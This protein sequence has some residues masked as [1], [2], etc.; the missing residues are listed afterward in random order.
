M[1]AALI[2]K[3]VL[4]LPGTFLHELAHFTAAL[5]LGKPLGFSL[6]P[7]RS[8]NSIVFGSTTARVRYKVLSVFI[9]LAPLVWWL[10]L[11]F[12]L[13]Y[14][15]IIHFTLAEPNIRFLMPWEKLVPPSLHEVLFLWLAAQLLWAGRLSLQDIKTLLGGIFSLSGLVLI[16]GSAAGYLI[17]RNLLS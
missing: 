15:R 5:L 10:A 3:A 2:I 12:L 14:F 16:A 7:R 1:N 8:G 6:L 17:F 9:S 13:N 11:L 4:F